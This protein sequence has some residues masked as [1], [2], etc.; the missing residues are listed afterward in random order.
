MSA[1]PFECPEHGG[2][3]VIDT[4]VKPYGI[5]KLETYTCAALTSEPTSLG[6]SCGTN[7]GWQVISPAGVEDSG[8]GA[9]PSVSGLINSK[10]IA[11]SEQWLPLF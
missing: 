8:R 7:V 6:M 10:R 11:S 2:N 5:Y 1:S 9:P 3:T 4:A